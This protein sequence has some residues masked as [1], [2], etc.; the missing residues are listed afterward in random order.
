MSQNYMQ[1]C[2]TLSMAHYF[3]FMLCL[4]KILQRVS[5]S[6]LIECGKVNAMP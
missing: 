2:D 3:L 1:T 5:P 4:W 6:T